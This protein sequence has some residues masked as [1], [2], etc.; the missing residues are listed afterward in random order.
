MIDWIR[1]LKDTGIPYRL[2]GD[3][4][5]HEGW[6]QVPCPF[7]S[8]DK[9]NW[10]LGLSLLSGA[11]NCWKCG[12]HGILQTVSAM[13]IS[14]VAGGEI[15]L[16]D[17]ETGSTFTKKQEV[18][19]KLVEIPGQTPLSPIH[20]KYLCQRKFDVE[21][22]VA[23][24]DLKGTSNMSGRW[25]WRITSP[26]K[27]KVGETV[28][29]TGRSVNPDVSPRWLHSKNE[30]AGESPKKFLYGIEKVLHRVLIVEG[31]SDV[32]RM[33]PG[34]VATLGI[35][36]KWEQVYILQRIP[37]RFI[38]YDPERTAL[39]RAEM[40]AE[41]LSGHGGVVEILKGHKKDPGD[42]YQRDADALM[43]ELGF[44]R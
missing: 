19:R 18:N 12:P 27:N 32:W 11:I 40:L 34:A 6:V 21:K 24:W 4:A 37:N 16:S 3:R 44:E 28:A 39:K 15:R 5:C 25:N 20:K 10:Y 9:E 7:C 30:E 23:E 2:T 43:R 35:S 14:K 36:W 38:L 1:L 13:R 31:P 42:F 29:Y 41:A 26:I 22:I 33:G 8:P 17:Y